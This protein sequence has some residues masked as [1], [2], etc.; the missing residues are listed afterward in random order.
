M[1]DPTMVCK[2]CRGACEFLNSCDGDPEGIRRDRR[3]TACGRVWGVTKGTV[4]LLR[5]PP[6]T[7]SDATV[8]VESRIKGVRLTT[9]RGQVGYVVTLVCGHEF[10]RITR[11][12]PTLY[13]P[14]VCDACTRKRNYQPTDPR[15]D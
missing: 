4:R 10:F 1:S 7:P 8:K 3:C 2:V 13:R 11:L 6:M 14:V 15:N 5:L 9:R 12:T